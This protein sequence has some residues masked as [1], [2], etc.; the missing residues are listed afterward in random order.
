MIRAHAQWRRIE[1][2]DRPDQYVKRM[3]TNTYLGWRRRGWFRRSVSCAEVPTV[4]IADTSEASAARQ[5]MWHRLAQL[6][7]RQRAAVVLRYYE[8][9]PDAEIAEILNCAVGT[10]RSHISRALVALRRAMEVAN[11][12]GGAS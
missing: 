5:D 12:Q 3:V 10:V 8:D 7:P 9:L 6:P 11:A 2:A 4:V 1:K